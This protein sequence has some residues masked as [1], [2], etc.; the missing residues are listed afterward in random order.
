MQNCTEKSTHLEMIPRYLSS[1]YYLRSPSFHFQ[2]KLVFLWHLPHVWKETKKSS[3][4][5]FIC[6]VA[7]ATVFLAQN[8]DT[9]SD[10]NEGHAASALTRA[11]AATML[12]VLIST[13]VD[14][15]LSSW[16]TRHPAA[17]EPL[18]TPFR[19]KSL[20]VAGLMQKNVTQIIRRNEGTTKPPVRFLQSGASRPSSWWTLQQEHI[21]NLDS[22]GPFRID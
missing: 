20:A 14:V 7:V 15:V 21:V 2:L 9:C 11:F 19:F 4:T 6:D 16:L 17:A 5:S 10:F 22:M 13:S 1:E 18:S 8:L 3:S 12:F